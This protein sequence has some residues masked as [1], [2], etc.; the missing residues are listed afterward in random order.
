M[1]L[2]IVFF[3]LKWVKPISKF[4]I[5]KRGNKHG[6]EMEP[7]K[8]LSGYGIKVVVERSSLW[9]NIIRIFPSILFI[10]PWFLYDMICTKLKCPYPD[11]L[12]EICLWHEEKRSIIG[13]DFSYT[14]SILRENRTT[15]IISYGNEHR[16]IHSIYIGTVTS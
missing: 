5:K 2:D 9:E 12:T 4:K 11:L 6:I 10:Q 14:T 16:S 13:H 15:I 7:N 8:T 3:V 1:I